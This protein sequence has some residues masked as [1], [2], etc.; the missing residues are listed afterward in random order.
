MHIDL[1]AAAANLPTAWKSTIVGGVAGANIKILRMDE[2]AYE[3]EAHDYTEALVV[4]GRQRDGL[5][6][7]LGVVAVTVVGALALVPELG[8]LGA[9]IAGAIAM[10]CRTVAL[11]VL[12]WQRE[13][14]RVL[15]LSVPVSL[16]Q[17]AP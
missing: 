15:S 1:N 8:A 9:A 6:V 13:G 16:S 17:R 11:G 12:L 5:F 2:C 7:A 3:A 4:L 14:L 10:A